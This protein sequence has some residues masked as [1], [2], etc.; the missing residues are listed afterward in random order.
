MSALTSTLNSVE[1][2]IATISTG[3]TIETELRET[4]VAV[5]LR[6]DEKDHETVAVMTGEAEVAD[7]DHRTDADHQAIGLQEVLKLL[8]S[9]NSSYYWIF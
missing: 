8:Q 3:N 6:A 4:E 2:L 9:T 1:T 7:V 5:D